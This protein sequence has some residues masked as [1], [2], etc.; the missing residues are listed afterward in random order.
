MCTYVYIYIYIC[1][2]EPS[3]CDDHAPFSQLWVT[4]GSHLMWQA[5]FACWMGDREYIK[6]YKTYPRAHEYWIILYN[7][8]I[9]LI[10]FLMHLNLVPYLQICKWFQIKSFCWNPAG[11]KNTLLRCRKHP[12]SPTP[13]LK[14]AQNI[15]LR[16]QQKNIK[17]QKHWR[18]TVIVFTIH[19]LWW[20]R[21]CRRSRRRQ[22]RHGVA[23]PQGGRRPPWAMAMGFLGFQL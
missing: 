17:T 3:C 12:N 2:V 23:R 22:A 18:T 5:I 4:A 16:N 11:N 19:P 6:P 13:H 1:R 7:I 10:L 14:T 21:E 20:P 9:W 8:G 15:S